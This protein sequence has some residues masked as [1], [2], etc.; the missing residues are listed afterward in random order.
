MMIFET[1]SPAQTEEV[2]AALAGGLRPGS[3][4]LLGGGLGAGKTA[5]V[6]GLVRG[7]GGDEEEVS[8]PTF[9]LMNQYEGRMT[10]YHFDLYRLSGPDE[11]YDLG[12]D[13]IFRGG[14]GVCAVEWYEVAGDL[15][16]GQ[17][18]VR[19]ALDGQEETRTIT[20]EGM[21]ELPDFGRLVQHGIGVRDEGR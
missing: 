21:D 20:V 10:V 18:A 17:P 7:L 4:L 14:H 11:V 19:V 16:E 1:H 5:F 12:F 3:V 9:A 8:S 15:F 6:R 13:E 2:A